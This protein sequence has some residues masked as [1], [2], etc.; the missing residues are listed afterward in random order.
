MKFDKHPS[1]D[2]RGFT[3]RKQTAFANRPDRIRRKLAMKIP[4]FADQ[5][6]TSNQ[7]S[8]E[9]EQQRRLDMAIASHQRM[10]DLDAKHWRSAR[11]GYFALPPEIRSQVK[12]RW[13]AFTGPKKPSMLCYF[14]RLANGEYQQSIDRHNEQVR[15]IREEIRAN[16]ANQPFLPFAGDAA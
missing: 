4:L 14:V 8:L 2:Y 16:Q 7:T 5:V 15:K 11:R 13:Q 6:D 1:F 10:R 3:P 9:E 12:A